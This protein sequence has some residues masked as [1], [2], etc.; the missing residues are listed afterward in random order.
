M[1]TRIY[2]GDGDDGAN[3]EEKKMPEENE[4]GGDSMACRGN[5]MEAWRETRRENNCLR[6]GKG[7]EK[8]MGK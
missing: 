6:S 5:E 7:T 8:R 2:T 4:D 1:E 3:M